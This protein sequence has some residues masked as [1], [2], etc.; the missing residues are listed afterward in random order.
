V[1]SDNKYHIILVVRVCL[2]ELLGLCGRLIQGSF[3]Q[4]QVD[5]SLPKLNHRVD[6]LKE[7]LDQMVI[8]DEAEV[9]EYANLKAQLR[10][11]HVERRTFVN[12]ANVL[13]PFLQAGRLIRTV[14]LAPQLALMEDESGAGIPGAFK[15]H[16]MAA[17]AADPLLSGLD[18][19]LAW[20]VVL[21]FDHLKKD[22]PKTGAENTVLV[23]VLINCAV[24]SGDTG[25]KGKSHPMPHTKVT[26]QT[27]RAFSHTPS[28]QSC[29]YLHCQRPRV[30][31][32]KGAKHEW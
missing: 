13:V 29:A 7:N 2:T 9:E 16:E 25:R 15:E 14:C 19:E 11:L 26:S 3:R 30:R 4:F 22:G 5:S 27:V 20:G 8:E 17:L 18:E 1:R 6:Q 32:R 24:D 10:L 12:D 31:G 23:D 28:R 21:N